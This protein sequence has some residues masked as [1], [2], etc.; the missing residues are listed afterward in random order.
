M[1][2][3]YGGATLPLPKI[4]SKQRLGPCINRG[5]PLLYK[6]HIEESKEERESFI[7]LSFS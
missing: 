5:V 6:G 3:C 7:L 1:P 2:P 4:A